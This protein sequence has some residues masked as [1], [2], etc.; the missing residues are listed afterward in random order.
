MKPLI[1]QAIMKLMEKDTKPAHGIRSFFKTPAGNVSDTLSL[2]LD[3]VKHDRKISID[4][5]KCTGGRFNKFDQFVNKEYFPPFYDEY[6][7]FNACDMYQRMPGQNPYAPMDSAAFAKRVASNL[8]RLSQ[9]IERAEIKQAHDALFLGS[10]TLING[11]T[12][13]FNKKATHNK[14]P[15]IK[16]DQN[17]NTLIADI[18]AQIS[19][20][21]KDSKQ[22]VVNT[23]MV[24]DPALIKYV[25]AAVKDEQADYV[26][27]QNFSRSNIVM[28]NDSNMDGLIFHGKFSVDGYVILLWSYDDRYEI[29]TGFGLANEGTE[30]TYI[31]SGSA[32]IF[33]S[34]IRLD[35]LYAGISVNDFSNNATYS[36]LFGLK[37][38]NPKVIKG[39]MVP[40][41]C[42]DFV[43]CD[44]IKYGVKSAPLAV[45]TDIDRSATL[46]GCLT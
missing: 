25:L 41:A 35:M 36:N 43:T 4:I 28:P 22:P 46:S 42:P 10:V 13:S 31:P 23:N 24:C 39:K 38:F 45:P 26:D 3:I 40:Y 7:Q 11:D 19:V 44:S 30:T 15:A 16:W 6:A 29:P 37:S 8:V 18:A 12:I 32:V 9:K 1:R 21:V 34:D 20:I 5:A 27:P 14:V 33:P 2:N 17:N